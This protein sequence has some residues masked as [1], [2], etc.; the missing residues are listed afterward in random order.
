M[1]RWPETTAGDREPARGDGKLGVR[2]G[3]SST[4]LEV[5][6]PTLRTQT[7]ETKAPIALFRHSFAVVTGWSKVRASSLRPPIR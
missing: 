2:S 1:C 6:M 4:R 7:K 3:W 5:Y